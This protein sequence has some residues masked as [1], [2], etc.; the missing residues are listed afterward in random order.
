MKNFEI[1]LNGVISVRKIIDLNDIKDNSLRPLIIEEK[2]ILKTLK[3]FLKN[4]MFIFPDLMYQINKNIRMTAFDI[5]K[6]LEKL[7][8]DGFIKYV[9]Y[10][11]L[12]IIEL[13]K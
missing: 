10:G 3:F 7:N 9:C 4:E 13:K 8:T 11:D 12:L 1:L 2:I 6:A 5:V